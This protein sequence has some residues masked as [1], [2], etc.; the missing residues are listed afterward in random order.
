[1]DITGPRGAAAGGPS[2]TGGGTPGGQ[3]GLNIDPNDL[4]SVECECGNDKFKEGHIIKKLSSLIS[5]SGEAGLIPIQVFICTECGEIPE[6]L[7]PLKLDKDEDDDGDGQIV[8]TE[9]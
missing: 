8:E 1:M 6:Q 3:S 5:P 7:N 9:D 2:P 4:P